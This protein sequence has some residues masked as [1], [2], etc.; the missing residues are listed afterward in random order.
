[1]T[2]T[3]WNKLLKDK[4][5]SNSLAAFKNVISNIYKHFYHFALTVAL[6]TVGSVFIFDST[7]YIV[8]QR[9]RATLNIGF[10]SSIFY[11]PWQICASRYNTDLLICLLVNDLSKTSIFSNHYH[12]QTSSM[13]VI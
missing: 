13:F 12:P 3:E 7:Q 11:I 1:V 9:G 4:A 10:L 5:L 2:I 8:K 6:V